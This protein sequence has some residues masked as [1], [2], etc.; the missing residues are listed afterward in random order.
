MLR[1]LYGRVEG[2]PS[3]TRRENPPLLRSRTFIGFNGGLSDSR[4]TGRRWVFKKL[5]RFGPRVG[6]FNSLSISLVRS[7]TRV[8]AYARTN[9]S[10][11]LFHTHRFFP[12]TFSFSLLVRAGHVHVSTKCFAEMTHYFSSFPFSSFLFY[13]VKLFH[14]F[15][16]FIFYNV[17]LLKESD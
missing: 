2:L 9:I 8:Y 14:I 15:L 4:N 16:C 5:A 13:Y 10:P 11:F 17:P 12:S 6:S 1:R 3:K 7:F